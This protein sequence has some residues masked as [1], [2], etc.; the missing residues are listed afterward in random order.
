M[1][2]KAGQKCTAIRRII[3]PAAS[4]A[5]LVRA[6]SDALASVRV[7]NPASKDVDM[8]ALASHGQR[9][10]VAERIATLSAEA[11]IVHGGDAQFDVIDADAQKGSF[12]M[13]TLLHCESPLSASSVHSVEAFGPVATVLPFN[14]WPAYVAAL[15]AYQGL[16]ALGVG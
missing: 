1:T 5:D 11:S 3:A 9:D 10:E 13:P 7:G 2:V 12:F 6:L 15:V 8:G 4:S 16:R 14:A